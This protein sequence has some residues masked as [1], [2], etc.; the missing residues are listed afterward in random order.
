V[1]PT[2]RAWKNPENES[3]EWKKEKNKLRKLMLLVGVALVALMLA[4]APAMAA[5]RNGGDPVRGNTVTFGPNAFRNADIHNV[6]CFSAGVGCNNL[7]NSFNDGAGFRTGGL[8]VNCDGFGFFPS[9]SGVCVN[10]DAFPFVSGVNTTWCNFDGDWDWDDLC[11]NRFIVRNDDG[12]D[13]DGF[14]DG[15]NVVFVRP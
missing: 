5:D 9:N 14:W 11:A 13:A 2:L 15:N 4:A 12:F 3:Q 6:G 10:C 8:C 7:R 1:S